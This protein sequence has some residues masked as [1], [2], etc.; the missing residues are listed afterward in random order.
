MVSF[1]L[2]FHASFSFLEHRL[3]SH[4]VH[5]EQLALSPHP[6]YTP[7]PLFPSFISTQFPLQR[8]TCSPIH[9]ILSLLLFLPVHC[10][11]LFIYVNILHSSYQVSHL[12]TS[13]SFTSPPASMGALLHLPTHSL[14][15]ALALLYTRA[16]ISLRPK[17]CFSH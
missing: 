4:K 13:Y 2:V 5:P 6:S 16:S 10:I 12:E 1:S 17:G 15:L 8:R 3:L 7:P 9:M 11:Y 14:L